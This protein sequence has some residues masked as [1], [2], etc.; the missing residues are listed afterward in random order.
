MQS[1][2]RNRS[3]RTAPETRK[4]ASQNQQASLSNRIRAGR[5]DM[6]STA[7]GITAGRRPVQMDPPA[8]REYHHR[9]L[10]QST[11]LRRP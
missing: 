8:L 6:D 7:I 2:A 3:L 4:Q 1:A 11:Y 9:M 5:G 10:K